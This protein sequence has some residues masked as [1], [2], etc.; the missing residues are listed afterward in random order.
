MGLF[1][2]DFDKLLKHPLTV[3]GGVIGGIYGGPMGAAAGA[4]IGASLEGGTEEAVKAQQDAARAANAEAKRQYDLTRTDQAPWREA[5][6]VALGQM[7]SPDFNKDFGAADFQKDPGYDFRMA[8]GQKAID[9]GAAARGSFDSGRT[10]K[11]L[12]RYSQNVASDEYNNAYNRFNND[13]TNRFNRLSSIAGTGQIANNQMAQAG[14]NYSNAYGQNMAAYGNAGAAGA[15]GRA[16]AITNLANQGMN[17]WFQNQYLN[18]AKKDPYPQAVVG[19]GGG[20]GAPSGISGGG[21][22]SPYGSGSYNFGG[23][24]WG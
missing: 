20:A 12:T 14:Q 1:G 9:R 11:E 24:P 4:G 3:A 16:N 22:S 19:Y 6:S 18:L 21:Y 13:R 7:Q 15:M 2:K 8:E 5:G 10:M 23:N 17:A